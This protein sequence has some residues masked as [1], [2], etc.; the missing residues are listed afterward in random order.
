MTDSQGDAHRNT[1]LSGFH[2]KDSSVLTLIMVLS[3]LSPV[4]P[5]PLLPMACSFFIVH[6]TQEFW[7]LFLPTHLQICTFILVPLS[8]PSYQPCCNFFELV[9]QNSSSSQELLSVTLFPLVLDS[10]CLHMAPP[11]ANNLK[12]MLT[13][14]LQPSYH[15][16]LL[17]L[18]SGLTSLHS[19]IVPVILHP[20]YSRDPCLYFLNLKKKLL[21]KTCS[22]FQLLPKCKD[23]LVTLLGN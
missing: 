9:S 23:L 5:P 12:L 21:S 11:K 1:V 8:V 3:H 20:D 22:S 15:Q 6:T 10:C 2:V 4:K 17:L 18:K 16:D 7:H 14:L 19:F 13:Q